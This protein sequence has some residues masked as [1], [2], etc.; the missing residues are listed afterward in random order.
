VIEVPEEFLSGV[1]GDLQS[2]G[3]EVVDLQVGQSLC[4]LKV[5]APLANL[6]SYSTRLRSLTQGRGS[7]TMIPQGY[8]AIPEARAKELLRGLY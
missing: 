3:G 6:F 5:T 8:A 4:R 1:L 7:F 2:R